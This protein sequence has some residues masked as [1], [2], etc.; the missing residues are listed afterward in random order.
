[1]IFKKGCKKNR[2][3]YRPISIT[4]CLANVFE[5]LVQNRI[6]DHL[7]KH[8]VQIIPKFNSF[9]SQNTSRTQ[10]KQNKNTTEIKTETRQKQNLT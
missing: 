4:S 3:N 9:T 6:K 8:T 10:Q 5:K 2:D 7:K 1:M